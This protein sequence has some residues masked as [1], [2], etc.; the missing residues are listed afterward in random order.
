MPY[1]TRPCYLPGVEDYQPPVMPVP[2]LSAPVWGC[3]VEETPLA[4]QAFVAWLCGGERTRDWAA[5]TGTSG[6]DYTTCRGLAV[7]WGWEIRCREY[8]AHMRKISD[9]ASAPLRD[10]LSRLQAT[11]IRA[12][13]AALALE[14]LELEKAL[15]KARGARTEGE[16]ALPSSLDPRELAALRRVNVQASETL[17]REAAGL[18]PEDD[19]KGKNTTD[20]GRLSPVE[21][22]QMRV[23]RE[24][25]GIAL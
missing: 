10:A 9:E 14:A 12:H 21:L 11:R 22:E 13:E 15:A 23:L 1:M 24:K 5:A 20:F 6:L 3:Q 4:Y 7:R 2:T 17:R 18:P 19:G 16:T 25:A 8:W